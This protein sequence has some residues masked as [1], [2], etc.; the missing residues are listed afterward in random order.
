[1]F[2]AADVIDAQADERDRLEATLAEPITDE[3]VDDILCTV[4]ESG[5]GWIDQVKPVDRWPDGAEYASDVITRGGNLAI[6]HDDGWTVLT[7]EKLETGIRTAV[8]SWSSLQ[9][10]YEQHDANDA[11]NAVQYALFGTLVYG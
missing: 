7:R 2:G 9:D 3:M 8:G 5:I 4:F 6:K 1:M 11:D 10:W